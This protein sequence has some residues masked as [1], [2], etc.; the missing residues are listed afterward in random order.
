MTL[1]CIGTASGK[2]VPHRRHASL[3]VEMDGVFHLLDA[4]EGAASAISGM[5]IDIEQLGSLWISHT[6]ADHIAGLPML[7]QGMHLARRRTPLDILVPPGREAWFEQWL[8]GMY[9]FR[10]K[11][12]FPFTI[13]AYT[14]SREG[15]ALSVSVFPNRH[16]DTI[17][18][19]ASSHGVP[20][21]AWSF[22]LRA[23]EDAVLVTSDISGV[24]DIAEQL[25]GVRTVVL[26]AAHV[27]I[28]QAFDIALQY[29]LLHIVCTHIPPELEADLPALTQRSHASCGGRV[30][31]AEDGL[32][33]T[34]G[35]A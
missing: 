35:D 2:P 10:E 3:L 9:M 7:L 27:P 15:N 6:H 23:G 4:G 25:G 11:W 13:S 17:R 26:D 22:V 29:P 19:L 32:I 12:S 20:A 5:D 21:Q 30:L 33:L 1:T 18:E 34:T 31:F 8:E 24:E 14:Q 28:D 16:L